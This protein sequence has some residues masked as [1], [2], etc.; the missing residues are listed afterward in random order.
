MRPTTMNVTVAMKILAVKDHI[1]VAMSGIKNTYNKLSPKARKEEQGMALVR[2]YAGLK[3]LR[4]EHQ[5][6]F[7]IAYETRRLAWA[8]HAA[9]RTESRNAT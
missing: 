9:K 8:K 6:L 2:L 5:G 1:D 3:H 4:A 7:P